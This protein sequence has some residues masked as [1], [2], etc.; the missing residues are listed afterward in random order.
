MPSQPSFASSSSQSVQVSPKARTSATHS[1]GGRR[2]TLEAAV[3]PEG[4]EFFLDGVLRKALREGDV[5]TMSYNVT[6]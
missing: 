3:D 1:L 5:T 4:G 6:T 2:E